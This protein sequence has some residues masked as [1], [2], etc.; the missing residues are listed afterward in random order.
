MLRK[1]TVESRRN[2][3]WMSLIKSEEQV[4]GSGWTTQCDERQRKQPEVFAVN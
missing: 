3:P 2:I 4:L 1:D